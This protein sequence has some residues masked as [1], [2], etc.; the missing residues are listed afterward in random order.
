[1]G[2]F[3]TKLSNHRV[4]IILATILLIGALLRF[5]NLAEVA[6]FEYDDQYNS[7]LVYDLVKNHHLSLVGQETSYGGMFLGPWHYLFLTPFYI[8]TNL[9][10]LGGY[11]G[12]GV[13]GLLTVLSYYLVGRKL[14][15]LRVGL[16]A[17]F[18]RSISVALI[19]HDRNISP[20]YPSELVALW[21]VYFLVLLYQGKKSAFIVLALLSGLMFTVH[22]SILPLII[23]WF[24]VLIIYRP[25]V[26][27]IQILIRSVI[28]FLIPISPIVLFEIRHNFAHIKSFLAA[29]ASGGRESI[30]L[31]NKLAYELKL[32]LGNFYYPFD[33]WVLPTWV[34]YLIF[35]LI[36]FTLWKKKGEFFQPFH[37]WLFGLSLAVILIYYLIYPR[38]IPEYYFMALV[39]IIFLYVSA[40]MVSLGKS[41]WG[42]ILIAPFL[43]LIIFSN[44][45]SIIGEH[46]DPH[47]FNLE[48]KDLAVKTVVEH[49]RGKGDFSISYFTEYGR[50]YGFQYF[51][52][53]YGLEPR[54][55]IKPPIYSLVLPKNL[56]AEND[57]SASFGDIGIIFP[58]K[59]P[60]QGQ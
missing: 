29:T 20:P 25:K 23:V 14:F 45:K 15:S 52:T 58:E 57:L 32:N 30:S 37:R 49:Q 13:I 59:E 54:K 12:E 6:R 55:E 53:Y 26:L 43:V 41:M 19:G 50:H 39:P 60:Q 42:K 3:K 31:W 48:Q 2:K 36:I 24:L 9:H 4:L 18:L 16:L 34:G 51:F 1:M 44:I 38:H 5:Y 10:P 27:N 56:V 46:A 8:I 22:L 40:L 7:F 35:A 11:I 17:A 47:K 33:R 21:F 28:A